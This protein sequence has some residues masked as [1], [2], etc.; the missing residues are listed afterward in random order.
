MEP[1]TSQHAMRGEGCEAVER[2][3]LGEVWGVHLAVFC[4][5]PSVSAVLILRVPA[6][7]NVMGAM[8]R[9]VPFIKAPMAN[10]AMASPE[11]ILSRP[12]GDSS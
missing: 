12:R 4:G 6:W 11:E 10:R 3:S 9:C 5:D 2:R 7:K 8:N 1:I